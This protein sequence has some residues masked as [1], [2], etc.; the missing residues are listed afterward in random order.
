MKR[1]NNQ[2]Y[3]II[4]NQCEKDNKNSTDSIPYTA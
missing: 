2:P 3:Y 1:Y 4:E